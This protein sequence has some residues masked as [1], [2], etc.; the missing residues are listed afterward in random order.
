MKNC[1]NFWKRGIS[2]ALALMM[3]LS[4]LPVN[5]FA[6]PAETHDHTTLAADPAA[7][8]H[9]KDNV[10]EREDGPGIFVKWYVETCNACGQSR[11]VAKG[12]WTGIVWGRGDWGGG[13]PDVDKP[14]GCDHVNAEV[15]GAKDATCKAGGYTGDTYCNDCNQTVETGHATAVDPNNHAGETEVRNAV[16]ATCQAGGKTG[17][18]YCLDCNKLISAST[19]TQVDPNNHA[20]ETEVRGAE[21]ATCVAKGYT[22]DTYCKDCGGKISDGEETEIDAE[23]HDWDEGTVTTP[24]TCTAKGEKTLTCKRDKAHTETEEIAID[25]DAHNWGDWEKQAD[26]TFKRGCKNNSDHTEIWGEAGAPD[27]TCNQ[28]GTV[29][30]KD[31]TCTEDGVVGGTYC[32]FCGAGKEAAEEVI[33]TNGHSWSDVWST[34]DS[35]H[36]FECSACDEKK[37]AAEHTYGEAEYVFTPG[38]FGGNGKL[39]L[40]STCTV[41]GHEKREVVQNSGVKMSTVEATC[42]EPGKTVYSWTILVNR[43]K[44]TEK[45]EVIDPNK[46]ALGHLDPQGAWNPYGVSY[47]YNGE[48]VKL[49]G[50]PNP[51][52]NRKCTYVVA[53]EAHIMSEASILRQPTRD[54]E[55]WTTID[56]TICGTGMGGPI[57]PALG[58]NGNNLPAGYTVITPATCTEDGMATYTTTFKGEVKTVTGVV[59]PALGHTP[60]SGWKTSDARHW[61]FC[62][63]CRA[64]LDP[65]S[66]EWDEGTVT[67]PAACEDEGVMTY[68]C[69][70]CERTRTESISANGHAWGEW[71]VTIAPTETATGEAI[72]VCGNDATH[73]ETKVL[74]VLGGDGGDVTDPEWTYEVTLEPGCTTEGEGTYTYTDGTSLT[75]TIPATGHAWGAWIVAYEPSYT[76]QGAEIRTCASCGATETRA[77]AVLELPEGGFGD[78]G[79]TEIEVEIEDEETPLADMPFS[80]NPEDELTRGHLMYVLHWFEGSPEAEIS[81]FIDVAFEAY[82]STAIGW[83]EDGNIARGTPDNKFLP[84]VTVTRG[85][86]EIFLTRYVEYLGL[87]MEV[88]LIGEDSDLM[89]W[90][91]AEIILNEFFANLP[92]EA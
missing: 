63:R 60:S 69:T 12:R 75:V 81:T 13:K 43:Q 83:A 47:G 10:S 18:T 41:C 9:P 25:E 1:K 73:I 4:L 68:T 38:G 59:I 14:T 91:E 50:R 89:Y 19:D 74:P 46:P 54:T 65:A 3:C 31:P 2:L 71:T 44:V 48:H 32:T 82:Y 35:E 26:G 39:E 55:G 72:R 36:W 79:E 58:H 67:I 28:D 57:M 16:T 61:H 62:T 53:H 85:Q 45:R 87:D 17:D 77:I 84:D 8:E 92:V 22:G 5:V 88:I 6:A 15:R 37:D 90:A 51:N 20:G 21:D 86:M 30:H 64:Q 34:D 27:H 33:V 24:A 76:A 52:T 40:V 78:T 66:H 49:C 7:C 80:L 23:A 70:V 29:E 56:C 42:T 11:W